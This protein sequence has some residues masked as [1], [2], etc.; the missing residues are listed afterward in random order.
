MPPLDVILWMILWVL[1]A[2]AGLLIRVC[3]KC[4]CRTP[5]QYAGRK[6]IPSEDETGEKLTIT[7][8]FSVSLWH[9]GNLTQL[10]AQ[11]LGH[12]LPQSENRQ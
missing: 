2:S 3:S 9:A 4:Q 8:G 6:Q 7:A 10:M 12:S 11:R 1:L 5:R